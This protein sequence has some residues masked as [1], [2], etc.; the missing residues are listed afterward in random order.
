MDNLELWEP[1]KQK[2]PF[3]IENYN[4]DSCIIDSSI[5]KK[6][7]TKITIYKIKVR[8]MMDNLWQ[9]YKQFNFQ[10]RI[11]TMTAV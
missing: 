5:I 8:L 6:K 7:F 11:T 1:Y 10:L 2:V 4:N 9:L 3:Q